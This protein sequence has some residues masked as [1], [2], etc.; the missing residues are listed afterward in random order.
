MAI[1]KKII[2]G[3]I[4]LVLPVLAIIFSI[5]DT[6]MAF[7]AT[8]IVLAVL[9]VVKRTDARI[10]GLI[11]SL[12]F[13][14]S[15]TYIFYLTPSIVLAKSQG[16]VLSG[17]WFEALNWIKDNT[18]ECA[19]IATYWDPGHFITGIARKS[20]VFDGASQGSQIYVPIPDGDTN[21]G[22]VTEKYDNGVVQIKLY[23]DVLHDGE[24]K[25]A[26]IKDI[27]ITLYTDNETQAIEILKDY[28]KPGCEDEVYYIA[29]ADLIGKSH[30]WSYFSTWDPTKTENPKGRGTPM[31]LL[32]LQQARPMPGQ[33]AVIYVYPI[34]S[35]DAF[36]I[37]DSNGTLTPFLQQRNQFI[38]VSKLFYFDKSGQGVLAPQSDGQMPGML[39]LDPSRQLLV[40]MP[41]E[42]ENSMFTRM[43]FFHGQGLEHFE[44]IN[45]WG[46]EVK[47]FKVKF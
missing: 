15:I 42:V 32:N 44:F 19:V 41:P 20:V 2:L 16:T 31:Q 47:L 39:W 36:A 3:A 1:N 28:A 33:N 12:L 5:T 8:S 14:F 17:N 10:A 18:K 40:Y 25:R 6:T 29:S 43:F 45:S 13:I 22:L 23:N 26:R 30:W 38:K 11:I 4:I 9:V 46:G 24:I 35:Q 34:S 37:I 27:A 7:I 21:S